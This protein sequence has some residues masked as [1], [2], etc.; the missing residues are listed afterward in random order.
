M[1]HLKDKLEKKYSK[2]KFIYIGKQEHDEDFNRDQNYCKVRV[3]CHCTGKYHGLP[4][5][6][7]I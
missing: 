7:L 2:Q 5:G 4:I 3:H 1:L 6:S